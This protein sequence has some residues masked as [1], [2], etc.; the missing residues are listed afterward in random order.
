MN[1]S[2]D[3]ADEF[4]RH[5]AK[6]ADYVAAETKGDTVGICSAERKGAIS[7]ICDDIQNE[8]NSANSTVKMYHRV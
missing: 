3:E 2:V 5:A 4:D 7:S 6:D 8:I 1:F